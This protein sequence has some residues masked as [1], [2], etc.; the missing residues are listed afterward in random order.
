M[1]PYHLKPIAVGTTNTTAETKWERSNAKMRLSN[2]LAS[3]DFN[4]VVHR[5]NVRQKYRQS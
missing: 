2:D 5:E 1:R 3:D 4:R